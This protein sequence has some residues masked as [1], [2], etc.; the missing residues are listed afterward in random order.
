[1]S[2]PRFEQRD[3]VILWNASGFHPT[4]SA[5]VISPRVVT[6]L[7]SFGTCSSALIRRTTKF[8]QIISNKIAVTT[9]PLAK[10]GNR[11]E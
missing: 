6:A 4:S 3:S 1:V 7:C 10:D 5:I 9:V 11:K 8:R 2:W